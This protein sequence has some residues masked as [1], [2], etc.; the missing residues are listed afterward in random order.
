MVNSLVSYK[1]KNFS[2]SSST[3]LVCYWFYGYVKDR[4]NWESFMRCF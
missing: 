2:I 1:G 3:L 4:V